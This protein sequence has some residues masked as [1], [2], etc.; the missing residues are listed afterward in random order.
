[1]N[2]SMKG[3]IIDSKSGS[4]NCAW[5]NTTFCYKTGKVKEWLAPK[6]VPKFMA[7]IFFKIKQTGRGRNY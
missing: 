3:G 1:M 2:L 5:H 7:K 6:Q 4:I